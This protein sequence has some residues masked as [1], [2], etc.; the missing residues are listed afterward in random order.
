MASGLDALLHRP[1]PSAWQLFLRLPCVYLADLLYSWHHAAPS[2]PT[3]DAVS[4]VCI[5]DTHNGRPQLPDGDVLIHAG[6]LTQSGT[7]TELAS[8][9]AWLRRQT[10]PVKIVVAGNHDLL[11]DADFKTPRENSPA[12]EWGDI[13]YLKNEATTVT[14]PNGRQLQVYGSPLSP[15]HGNW[16]FQYPR[17]YDAWSAL[18]PPIPAGIDILVTHAPPRGHLDRQLGCVHL[19]QMLWRVRPRL[20]VFGHVHDGAGTELV[21]FDTLQAAYEQTVLDKGGLVNLCRVFVHFVKACVWPASTKS[22]CQL[23]N[24]AMVGGLLDDEVR[25]PVEV[26]L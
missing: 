2:Q 21:Q 16:A 18:S 4:I 13:V 26:V 1:R 12:L 23:V 11:L 22:T 17:S 9:V 20:H 14:C 6:D 24:A 10:H 8:T 25:R 19:L 15:K 5:S 3:V 7:H